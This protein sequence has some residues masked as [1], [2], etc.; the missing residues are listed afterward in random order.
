MDDECHEYQMQRLDS[1][2]QAVIMTCC[3]DMECSILPLALQNNFFH[4]W[5]NSFEDMEIVPFA[6]RHSCTHCTL[7]NEAGH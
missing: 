2:Y 4:A 3:I 7:Y 5:C 1:L 6:A